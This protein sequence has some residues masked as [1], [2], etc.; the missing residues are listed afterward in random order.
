MGDQEFDHVLVRYELILRELKDRS[1]I[2][3]TSIFVQALEDEMYLCGAIDDEEDIHKELTEIKILLHYNR[4]EVDKEEKPA[5]TFLERAI[6]ALSNNERFNFM[7]ELLDKG[8][9]DIYSIGGEHLK[10]LEEGGLVITKEDMKGNGFIVPTPFAR[11]L[12]EALFDVSVPKPAD[13]EE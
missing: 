12:I 1:H 9:M 13:K 6:K 4:E 3:P 10:Y 2:P 7:L 8:E 5:T 11:R